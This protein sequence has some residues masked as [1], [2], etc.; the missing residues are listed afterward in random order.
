MIVSIAHKGLKRLWE[1]DDGSKL[2]SKQVDKI[3]RMLDALDSAKT[4]DPLRAVPGYKL[5]QLGGD[6][7]GFWSVTVT[8]NYRIVFEFRDENVYL[9]DYLDYH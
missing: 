4:L 5:H 9:V 1:K 2:P 6:L 3:R 7:K 8:G